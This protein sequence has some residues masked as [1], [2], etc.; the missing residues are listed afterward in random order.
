MPGLFGIL[1]LE[2]GSP[3]GR[4]DMAI[5]F[6][7]MLDPLRHHAE[8]RLERGGS[9]ESGLLVGRIGL[10]HLNPVPWPGEDDPRIPRS[11]VAGS[12]IE[13]GEGDPDPLVTM[14]PAAWRGFFSALVTDPRRQ[15]TAIFADRRASVPVFHARVGRW[16]L[17]AP[18]VKALLAVAS[19]G[20][21][22]DEAALACLLAQGHLLA[23]QT[24]FR[25]VRRL[26]GGQLLRCEGGQ[27]VQE[28]YWRFAPGSAPDG[29]A[30]AELQRELGR[31]VGDAASRHLGDPARTVLFLSGGVDSR[32]ILGGALAA[33]GG[34]AATLHTVSWGANDGPADSDV[35]VAAAIAR[36]VGTAHRFIRRQVEQYRENFTR[37]N[38]L[39]DSLSDIA[40]FHPHEHQIMADLRA[41]GFER[42]LRGDEV[43]GW[44]Y[45]A[46]TLAG[47]QALVNLRRL[48]DVQDAG[49][50]I[51]PEHRAAL[52]DA[53]DGA[54]DAALN[55]VRGIDPNRAKDFLYFTHR[56]QCYLHTA[57][58]Y[59]QMELDQRNVLLDEPILD[60]LA[61][62]PEPLR[63]DKK[64]YR[65]A[66]ARTYPDLARLPSARRDNLED[67]TSLL[68][69][70]T[71]VRAYAVEELSDR[72]SGIWEYLD[73][74]AVSGLVTA[75]GRAPDGAPER[76]SGSHIRLRPLVRRALEMVA[77][78][79]A[80][81]I[82]ARR[83]ARSVIHLGPTNLV[84]RALVLKNWHDTF[85][86]AG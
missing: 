26:C 85:V 19:V 30:P 32:G 4:S 41:A 44:S 28:T 54:I 72:S 79:V 45:P 29:T 12:L 50:V 40:A 20:R 33:V 61:R 57:G 6:D 70:D 49:A 51:R 37:V 58:Y 13:G 66:M 78:K 21:E 65:D 8:D 71:P 60:F 84:L 18:E 3:E 83:A 14:A 2:L 9:V 68:T 43:F 36:K 53:S 75:L 5:I 77:P 48:R 38:R 82:Q 46:T 25:S 47:A 74:A 24:L 22:P 34:R 56:L 15:A 59:K 73:Q 52:D 16:L 1:D 86:A 23:D 67:W 42:V 81:R 11:F 69:A 64:L 39:V 55:E 31:L 7:E 76:G 35:A 17:F 63:F 62:V 80:Y 10:P 27:V